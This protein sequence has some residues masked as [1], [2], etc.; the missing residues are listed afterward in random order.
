MFNELTATNDISDRIPYAFQIFSKL[1][2][3]SHYH[4]IMIS[5]FDNLNLCIRNLN[6][7]I[8]ATFNRHH[9]VSRPLDHG[10]PCSNSSQYF[11]T[12]VHHLGPTAYHIVHC[13]PSR[14]VRVPEQVHH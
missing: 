12:R 4:F 9:L 13:V 7:N 14:M 6:F 5:T 1:F 10:H 2:F 3:S 8:V 11:K